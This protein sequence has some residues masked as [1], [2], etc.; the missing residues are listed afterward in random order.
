MTPVLPDLLPSDATVLT[1]STRLALTL[2]SRAEA[3]QHARAAA[4][5]TPVILPWQQWLEKCWREHVLES[6]DTRLLLRPAQEQLLWREVIEAQARGSADTL[7]V[8]LDA[9]SR[10]ALQAWNLAQAWRLDLRAPE[11]SQSPDTEA[12]RSWAGAFGQRCLECEALPSACLAEV[13]AEELASGGLHLSDVK[14]LLAGF[15]ELTPAQSLLLDA[16]RSGGVPVE[17]APLEG[18]PA[19]Q[20]GWLQLSNQD[21]EILRAAR[22]A[23]ALLEEHGEGGGPIGIVVPELSSLRTRVERI[24]TEVFHPEDELETPR[25]GWRAFNLSLGLP[26]SGYPVIQAALQV[27]D[28]VNAALRGRSLPFQAVSRWLRS[29][30]LGWAETERTRRARLDAELRAAQEIELTPQWLA[31]W[32][33]ATC[34]RLTDLLNHLQEWAGQAPRRQSYPAWAESVRELLLQAGWPGERPLDSAEHQT[35]QAFYRLLPELAR[36]D[37]VSGPVPFS[38]ALSQLRR[39]IAAQVFQPESV[40]APVQVLGLLESTGL[41]FRHLW[42]LGLHDGVWPAAARPQSF[43]PLELQ[44]R[45]QLPHSSA[46]REFA[47]AQRRM[48]LLLAAAPDVV[49][50]VPGSEGDADLHPSPLVTALPRLDA[51][52]LEFRVERPIERLRSAG[53]LEQVDDHVGPPVRT[54]EEV[55]GGSGI[56]SRQAACPFQAFAVHRLDAVSLESPQPGLNARQRGTL[57]HEVMEQ[58]WKT[59]GDQATLLRKPAQELDAI[60]AAV[61]DRV[62][63]EQTPRMPALRGRRLKQVERLCLIRV[64]GE[65]MNLERQRAPFRVVQQERDRKIEFAGLAVKL[66]ADRMDELADGRR[67]VIDYKTGEHHANA[68]LGA[69]P[70][71]PQLPLYAVTS[72]AAPAALAFARLRTGKTGFHGLAAE[73]GLLPGVSPQKDVDWQEQLEAWRQE[74]DRLAT[75]FRAGWAAVDPRDGDQTCRTCGLTALCR[76]SELGEAARA[77]LALLDDEGGPHASRR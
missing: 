49:F 17:I 7:P 60:I 6:G 76:V 68:W 29:P 37:H 14:L 2:R 10:N 70:E 11:W 46:A 30:W 72:E 54:A 16:V 67:V 53:A 57:L 41:R 61:V 50:S 56:F 19:T 43:L 38:T 59:L 31:R 42:V 32:A 40:P 62:L 1:V 52:V 22:W 9:T 33:S 73:A 45:H 35:V 71:Q 65:W 63:E 27:L 55:R 26:L 51:A 77:R 36:L 4:W 8:D 58:I 25:T 13:L 21:E 34:P 66:R 28:L 5:R 15:E 24:F 3:E 23:R 44:R 64:L 20:A 12:F 75:E 74:L 47:F 39:L 18:E 48:Q 69:R